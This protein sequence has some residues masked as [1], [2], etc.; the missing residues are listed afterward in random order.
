MSKTEKIELTKILVAIQVAIIGIIGLIVLIDT[1]PLLIVPMALF[2]ITVLMGLE[3][4]NENEVSEE[5]E[6]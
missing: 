5:E 6:I 4:D 3:S 1:K 2:G